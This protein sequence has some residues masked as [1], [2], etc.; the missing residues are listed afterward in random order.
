M[1]QL[2]HLQNGDNKSSS[3][4][5]LLGNS[6]ETTPTVPSHQQLRLQGRLD[7]V[8]PGAGVVDAVTRQQEQKSLAIHSHPQASGADFGFCALPSLLGQT[9]AQQK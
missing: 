1:P 7:P 8:R 9:V 6:T 2:P 4:T 5:G 3:L